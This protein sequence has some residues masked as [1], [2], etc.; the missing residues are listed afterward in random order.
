MSIGVVKPKNQIKQK[1]FITDD[2]L[3][4]IYDELER[5][6]IYTLLAD[7]GEELF[8]S[9]F[10][11]D[12][13]PSKRGRPTTPART[14]A[15]VMI[16]GAFE[17]LADEKATAKLKYDLRWKVAAG[18]AIDAP[19]FNYSVICLLRSRLLNSSSP[20]R[21]FDK[22]LSFAKDN[23]I[24]ISSIRS[25]D[26]TALYDSVQTKSTIRMIE[27]ALSD[28]ESEID[29]QIPSLSRPSFDDSEDV[30]SYI[31]AL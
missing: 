12:L 27:A 24:V 11:C 14:I 16:L 18:I 20:E 15:T 28:I 26:S 30:A 25:I 21:I 1:R 9:D 8:P 22:V 6:S 4:R 3:G 31:D 10:F 13:Y 19:V 5:P 29:Y 7:H 23:K 2:L 17:G